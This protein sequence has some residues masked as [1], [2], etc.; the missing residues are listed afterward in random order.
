MIAKEKVN[1]HDPG[2]Y[3]PLSLTKCIGK[4]MEMIILHR[5]VYFL[6]I[7]NIISNFHSGFREKRQTTDNLLYLSQKA[8]EA[9]SEKKMMCGVVMDIQ[10]AFDKV[11]HKGLIYK[12][13]KLLV[14][15]L[16][17]D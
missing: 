14:V 15:V 12:L 7:H 13:S 9:F 2:N 1:L 5:L 3:R 8:F 17:Y 4:L 16:I 6:N 11:W 10:K